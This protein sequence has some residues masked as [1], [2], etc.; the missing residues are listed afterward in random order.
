MLI[1]GRRKFIK[2]ISFSFLYSLF[3]NNKNIFAN[4]GWMLT[5]NDTKS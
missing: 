5:K 2:L 4:D 1:L 3:A